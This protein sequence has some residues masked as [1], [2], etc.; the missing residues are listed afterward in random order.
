MISG[1]NNYLHNIYTKDIFRIELL[2]NDI[3]DIQQLLL[4]H[5]NSE[6]SDK[7][8]YRTGNQI[9]LSDTRK[10]IFLDQSIFI[11]F[12]LTDTKATVIACYIIDIP[13]TIRLNSVL[14]SLRGA[15]AYIDNG[16]NMLGH[17]VS[18]CRRKNLKWEIYNDLNDHY[19]PCPVNINVKICAVLYSI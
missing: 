4:Q 16:D 8:N 15:V 11:S 17:F 6:S 13:D 18:F 1:S 2:I 12:L 3:K 19:T 9:C 10:I 5:I 7:C 14:Y